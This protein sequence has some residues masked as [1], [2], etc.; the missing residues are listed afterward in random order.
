MKKIAL[1]LLALGFAGFAHAGTISSFPITTTPLATSPITGTTVTTTGSAPYLA[2]YNTSDPVGMANGWISVISGTNSLDYYSSGAWYSLTPWSSTPTFSNVGVGAAPNAALINV[3]GSDQDAQLYT[4]AAPTSATSGRSLL[5]G[6]VADSY[7]RGVLY[8]S[9]VLGIGPGTGTRDVFLGRSAAGTLTVGGAY[10]L[11]GTGSLTVSGTLIA[12][13]STPT[14]LTT[15]APIGTTVITNGAM[16]TNLTGW[17]GAN[18]AWNAAN[19]GE[20]LHTSGSTTAL[21]SSNNVVGGQ[22]YIVTYTVNYV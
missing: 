14:K 5:V 22:D 19:G 6:V 20:A 3:A 1:V 13:V 9:G 8:S 15:I 17:S 10:D 4:S 7:A 16:T 12:G 11:S 21:S 2:A 18:W